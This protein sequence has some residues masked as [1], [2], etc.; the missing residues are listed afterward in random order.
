MGD[1]RGL[2]SR[3]QRV[4]VLVLRRLER[5]WVG[6]ARGMVQ[7][8]R[9]GHVGLEAVWLRRRLDFVMVRDGG[10]CAVGPSDLFRRPVFIVVVD[11]CPVRLAL[12]IVVLL[13]TGRNVDSVLL[14][15]LVRKL[16]RFW[17]CDG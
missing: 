12:G 2:G 11:V 16:A 13:K 10:L 5:L 15:F 6:V 3:C 4:L 7:L 17:R 8:R 1:R 9:V 14:Q